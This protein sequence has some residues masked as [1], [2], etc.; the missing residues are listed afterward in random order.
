M[1]KTAAPAANIVVEAPKQLAKDAEWLLRRCTKPSQKEY[2]KIVQAVLMGFLVMGFVGY[3]TKLIH[4]PINNIIGGRA[5][6]RGKS[7]TSG[8]D[9]R[10]LVFKEDL[11]EYAQ[12]T[13]VLGN[14]RMEVQCFDK[15]NKKRLGHIR[16]AMRKKVWINLG[17]YV[18]V[19]LRE[20]QDQKCDIVQKYSDEEVSNLRKAEQLPEKSA[21]A[22]DAQQEEE[23]DDLVEFDLDIDEL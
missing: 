5:F 16:G 6:K 20:F 17:D 1:E 7:D 4:I 15:E 11:Q 21:N 9:K 23:D 8:Q 13:K 10:E 12:V 3:F 22:G 19:S 18:L 2:L 14:G